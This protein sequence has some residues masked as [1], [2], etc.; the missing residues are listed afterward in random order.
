M[1]R[2]PANGC[3]RS[4][5]APGAYRP[6]HGVSLI[7]LMIAMAIGLVLLAALSTLYVANS[8][9][10]NEFS[11]T[12][13]QV[14]NGRFATQ[15]IQRDV[16]MSGFFGRASLLPTSPTYG[17]PDLCATTQATLGF[18]TTGGVTLPN[19]LVG[20][21]INAATPACLS[22][23]NVVPNSEMLTVRYVSGDVSAAVDG[24]NFFLQLSQCSTDAVPLVFSKVSTDFS[25]QTL[26]CNGKAAELRQYVVR[27]YFLSTCDNCSPSDNI[28]TLKVAE[29]SGGAVTVSSLVEGIQ[30][31]HYSYGVDQDG[32]GS[33]DCYVDDP[34]IDNSATCTGVATYSWANAVTNWSNVTAVR[35]SVL[36]RNTDFTVGWTD[37]RTYNL[38]RTTVD[39]GQTKDGPY[40]DNYKRHV[41]TSLARVWNTGGMREIH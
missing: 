18:G 31:I 1:T 40:N 4:H 21:A 41:Y 38:G 27:T 16:A 6:Q 19:S 23:Y 32:N 14:E 15:S 7:E 8:K 17:N 39:G 26:S 33:P 24:T 5:G 34:S 29:L 30:D 35:V 10:H 12:S 11:K 37:N 36:S 13:A 25:L 20:R 2:L 3:M 22:T 9:N 28:P